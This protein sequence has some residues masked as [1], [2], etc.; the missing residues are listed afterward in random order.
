MDIKHE[1][2]T[3]IGNI[4]EN[5]SP[6]AIS[7]EK[8]I[9]VKLEE[10]QLITEEMIGEVKL[11]NQA[12]P[13]RKH[14]DLHENKKRRKINH[15]SEE[16]MKDNVGKMIFK[17]IPSDESLSVFQNNIPED[18]VPT[19]KEEPITEPENYPNNPL[20]VI[21]VVWKDDG[22]LDMIEDDIAHKDEVR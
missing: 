19:K 20:S 9:I 8:L 17:S 14:H 13:K 18:I 16:V 10:A 4:K 3:N 11:F 12:Q 15:L 1:K 6:P 22:T 2:D 5:E 7:L 21:F